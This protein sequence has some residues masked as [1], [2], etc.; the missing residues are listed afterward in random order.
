MANIPVRVTGG[1]PAR[2]AATQR[3]YNKASGRM[4]SAKAIHGYRPVPAGHQ[5]SKTTHTVTTTKPVFNP[6]RVGD[7]TKLNGTQLRAFA[8]SLVKKDTKAAT[9]PFQQQSARLSGEE[10]NAHTRA[11]GM[12]ATTQS[13]LGGI[14]GRQA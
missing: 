6:D 1:T 14:A 9:L 10:A 13:L 5:M 2:K 11:A 7:W 3:Y 12:S 4:E 8:E